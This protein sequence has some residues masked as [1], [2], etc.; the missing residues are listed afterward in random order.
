MSVVRMSFRMSG[1]GGNV[2]FSAPN[3]DR[4]PFFVQIPLI[5]EHLFCKYFFRLSVGNATKGFAI[6]DVYIIKVWFG[7]ILDN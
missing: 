2:I 3:C 1:L 5:N 4:A 7:G 6:M